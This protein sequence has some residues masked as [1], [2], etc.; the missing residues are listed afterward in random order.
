MLGRADFL[1]IEAS[2]IRPSSRFL[3]AA[4]INTFLTEHEIKPK[5]K[6]VA[7]IGEDLMDYNPYWQGWPEYGFRP[8]ADVAYRDRGVEVVYT[9]KIAVGEKLF[10][11]IFEKIAASGAQYIDFA[12]SAYSDFY[13]L[14]K[15]W[16]TSAAKDIPI[17][18]SGVSPKYWEITNGTCLG[19]VGWWPSDIT[20]Y[21]VVGK[22]REYAQGFNKTFGYPGS[23]WL[24]EGAY[25]DVLFWSEG[26][27][28][29]GSPDIEK[30]IKTLENIEIDGVRGKIK[31]N[32][33]DHTSH[34]F[35]YKKGFVEDVVKEIA[36]SSP[37]N[38]SRD[39]GRVFKKWNL[40]PYGVFPFGPLAPLSQWQNDGKIVLLYPPELAKMSN[41]GQQYVPIKELRAR[42]K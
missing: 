18:H 10:L 29:T 41:P 15:Q 16:A 31:I 21:E 20:N 2:S 11:P 19:M 40:F 42:Q 37:A 1:Q 28:K 23:N 14:A 9:S 32:P 38:M 22:T 35:P 26:I 6:K 34:S 3:S 12:M 39:M 5:P 36:K 24:A 8:Y 4:I 27:K 33:Q 7:I 13:V 25:D 30:L 17:F